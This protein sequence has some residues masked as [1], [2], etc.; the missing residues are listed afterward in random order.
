MTSLPF[1]SP[2]RREAFNF[3]PQ[4]YKGWDWELSLY[5]TQ[6]RTA[7]SLGLVKGLKG[8]WEEMREGD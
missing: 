6:V 1:L 4:R 3:T 2:K 5:W 8:E 7:I